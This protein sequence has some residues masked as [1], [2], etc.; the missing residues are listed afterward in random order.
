MPDYTI[1][2]AS[3]RQYDYGPTRTIG[4]LIRAQLE[5]QA[6]AGQQQAAL[7]AQRWQGVGHGIAGTIGDI[8]KSREE[9]PIRA[10]ELETRRLQL[11]NARAAQAEHQAVV[12]NQQRAT[13]QDQAFGEFYATHPDLTAQD[14]VRFYGPSVGAK[15][16]ADLQSLAPK[17]AE[18]FTLGEGQQRFDAT[19]KPIAMGPPKVE[20]PPTAPA[21]GSFEDYVTRKYGAS[22][23]PDQITEARKVYQQAD[24]RPPRI[25]VNTGTQSI[26]GN[27]DVTG[28]AFLSSIPPQWRQT[29]KKIAAYDE[30]PTKV[31]SMR[32]GMR[33]TLM[34]WVNQ[35][36]PGY[37]QSQFANRSTTRKAYT[38]GT[39]GKQINNIN[40][41]IGHIDQ[42]TTV[43]DQLQN[44]GFVPGNRAWNSLRTM[45]GAD[46]VTN[47]D[48]LKD[49]LAGEVAGALSQSGATV[50]G[51]ADAQAKIH[52]SSSP[53]QL[54]GYV[55]T[56]IPVMGSKLASLDYQYH[57]A[58]GEGDTFSALS[59]DSKRI[60]TKHGFDPAHPTIGGPPKKIGRFEVEVQP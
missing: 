48:T 22:P 31:A 43:A 60:L 44:G 30:D 57:Q 7:A 16:W 21:V 41:A 23:T 27:F 47:F 15:K 40:T 9:A 14:V 50:S 34:Q 58:M 3:R 24:D 37:D 17:P 29:V 56:L 10:A 18:G 49:A 20:K 25:T 52:A 53:T 55:K 46:Q 45:F 19:G 4:D 8:L 36:N 26:P 11:D 51:I 5:V 32:G 59:P 35:V 13:A 2:Y 42:L 28:E 33:E 6:H 54:A 39:Q 38:T 12:A 1:P